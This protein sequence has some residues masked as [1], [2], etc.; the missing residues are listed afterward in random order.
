MFFCLL[1][2]EKLKWT[3]RQLTLENKLQVGRKSQ[4]SWMGWKIE[5]REGHSANR[6]II[7]KR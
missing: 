6:W 2:P 7:Q 1:K 3:L 4:R 5:S